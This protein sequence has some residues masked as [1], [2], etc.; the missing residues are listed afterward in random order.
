MANAESINENM[1]S[2][3]AFAPK[4]SFKSNTETESDLSYRGKIFSTEFA[5]ASS[6]YVDR[7]FIKNTNMD[8]DQEMIIKSIP[9]SKSTRR[10]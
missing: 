1:M 4:R 2:L 9:M 3:E 6:P 8:L 10:S 5:K 7:K